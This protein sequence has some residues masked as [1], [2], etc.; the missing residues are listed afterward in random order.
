M[1]HLVLEKFGYFVEVTL[2]ESEKIILFMQWFYSL[3][4][5]P[6]TNNSKT[7]VLQYLKSF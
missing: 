7:F 4:K 1:M 5:L 3:F 6:T 2:V